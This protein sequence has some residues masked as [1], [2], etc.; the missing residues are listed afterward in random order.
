MAIVV[1]EYTDEQS[2]V[3]V[4]EYDSGMTKNKA[5][6]H[7]I[8]PKPVI[9]SDNAH[10]MLAARQAKSQR[11]IREGLIAAA[12]RTGHIDIRTSSRAVGIAAEALWAEGVMNPDAR[13]IDRVKAFDTI[14]KAAGLLFDPRAQQHTTNE[15]AAALGGIGAAALLAAMQE[16]ERRKSD[17]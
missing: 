1:R 5:N 17:A 2:G 6:G 13:L 7:I 8:R 3:T 9:S 10:A 14:G 11:A 16:I 15:Q 4:V 12:A